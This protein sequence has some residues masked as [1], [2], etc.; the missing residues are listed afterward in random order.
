[1]VVNTAVV[2]DFAI[3]QSVQL[4]RC[5]QTEMLHVFVIQDLSGTIR[6][7]NV[8]ETSVAKLIRLVTNLPTVLPHMKPTDRWAQAVHA[9]R[10]KLEMEKFN[11]IQI[12]ATQVSQNL[13][14]HVLWRHFMGENYWRCW[15]CF[16][17]TFW[18]TSFS[19]LYSS[20]VE[21]CTCNAAAP[22]SN[23]GGA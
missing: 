6:Q 12:N 2:H 1:M 8:W 4:E 17:Y 15:V 23:P 3:R 20:V 5:A 18:R 14:R 22:G 13:L 21:R 11:A 16:I 9:E 7:I 10:E 19:W